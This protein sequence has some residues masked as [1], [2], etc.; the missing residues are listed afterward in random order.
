MHMNLIFCHRT[1]QVTSSYSFYP[2]QFFSLQIYSN[3]PG[4]VAF[5][6]SASNPMHVP[7]FGATKPATSAYTCQGP[8][9][10]DAFSGQ[11]RKPPAPKPEK[12]KSPKDR[13]GV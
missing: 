13:P 5:G 4:P 9:S 11:P 7:S 12:L 2:L 1:P 3:A 10:L 8:N 6:A